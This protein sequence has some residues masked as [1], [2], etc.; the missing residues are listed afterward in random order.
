M[1]AAR[2]ETDACKLLNERFR[3]AMADLDDHSKSKSSVHQNGEYARPTT[4]PI[5]RHNGCPFQT[6]DLLSNHEGSNGAPTASQPPQVRTGEASGLDVLVKGLA[7]ESNIPTDKA[8]VTSAV[9]VCS[10]DETSLCPLRSLDKAK[11]EDVASF[12]EHHKQEIPRSHEVCVKRYRSN[13]DAIRRL[14]SQYGNSASM[15]EGLGLKH[16]RMLQDKHKVDPTIQNKTLVDSGA[17]TEIQT[18][19]NE[20]DTRPN[21]ER[22]RRSDRPLREIRVGESPTRPWGIPVPFQ[23]DANELGAPFN[24]EPA[25]VPLDSLRGAQREEYIKTPR[26][27]YVPRNDGPDREPMK[28]AGNMNAKIDPEELGLPLNITINGPIF[29]GYPVDQVVKL[30]QEFNIRRAAPT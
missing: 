17:K 21:E 30:V 14:D 24:I 5:Q 13:A 10:L 12:L 9:G 2:S 18:S 4:P 11:P 3:D 26:S 22:S 20:S 7:C 27:S 19:K 1:K 28:D 23:Q 16:Q 8:Q 29:L 15:I 25:P 6:S